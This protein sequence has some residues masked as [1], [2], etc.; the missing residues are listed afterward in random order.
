MSTDSVARGTGAQTGRRRQSPNYAG[1]ITTSPAASIRMSRNRKEGGVAE[2]QLRSALW[3]MGFRFRIHAAHLPGKPD[4][5]FARERI[6]VFCDG[7]FWHGR[8]W[9]RRKKSLSAGQN[10]EYWVA[11][12]VSNRARDRRVRGLLEKEG[13]RVIRLWETDIHRDPWIPA[14]RVADLVRKHKI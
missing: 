6:A 10:A 7:D 11:K 3:R 14:N 13:W 2:R 4:L 9:A 12:I 5:V 8:N 1:F